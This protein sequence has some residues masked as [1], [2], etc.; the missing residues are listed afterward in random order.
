M[1]KSILIALFS[2]LTLQSYAE[3]A[4]STLD[5]QVNVKP[6]CEMS[7]SPTMDFGTVSVTK[8]SVITNTIQVRCTKTTPYVIEIESNS[9]N[10]AQ[11]FLTHTDGETKLPYALYQSW[12]GSQGKIWGA[13]SKGNAK[14]G[15]ATGST[16]TH[17]VT[18]VIKRD[19]IYR[20]AGEYSET[21]RVIVKH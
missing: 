6:F 9:N 16:E 4:T 10:D 11:R 5:I 2:L 21:V 19:D 13:D 18:G 8:D 12:T 1:K 20:K 14:K 3:E 17:T 7:V 15:N